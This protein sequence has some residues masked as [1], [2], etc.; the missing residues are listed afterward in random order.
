MK[1]GKIYDIRNLEEARK[2]I[3][4]RVVASDC[5]ARI[6]DCDLVGT[7]VLDRIQ[8]DSWYPFYAGRFSFQFIREVIEEEK[9]EPK[10]MT[11]RQLAEWA[12]KRLGQIKNG[13][14]VGVCVHYEEANENYPPDPTVLIRPWD[15][16][17]WVR[18][19]VD[20]Y[21]RDCIGENK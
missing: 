7:F 14:S 10:L 21:E 1:L 15:S 4:K 18:P 12:S 5:L 9:E 19:T 2:L 3:G 11:N 17:E 8:E 6:L 20:I 13:K 16:D